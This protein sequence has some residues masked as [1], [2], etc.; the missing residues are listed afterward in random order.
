[1]NFQ[2]TPEEAG[3]RAGVRAWL[4]QHAPGYV[5]PAG[6]KPPHA[7]H[8]RNAKAW[9]ALKA[10][11]GFVGIVWPKA[12]GGQGGTP[13]QQ[14]IFQQEEQR[15][16]LPTGVFSIGLGMCLPTLFTHGAPE[17]AARYV[18]PAMR[19]DEIW[20][21]LFSEPAGGSDVAA[22]RTRAVRVAGKEGGDDEWVINGQ[23]VWTSG[24]KDCDY[25]LLLART[26]PSVPKHAGLTMFFIDM[27]DPAVEVRPI[28]SM[29][30]ESEFNEVFFTDL[31]ISDRQR[32]G[33]PGAGWKVSLTTLMFERLAVGGR[34]ATAPSLDDLM[35]L[36][37]Q[38]GVEPEH[39]AQTLARFYLNDQGIALTRLRLMTALSR[40]QVPGPEAS[41]S[42]LVVAKNLQEMAG[43]AQELAANAA[44]DFDEASP[45]HG[46]TQWQMWSAGLRI[47]GGTDEILRNIIAERVLGLPPEVRLDK[48]TPYNQL[49]A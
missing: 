6:P 38:S 34:P 10:G 11:A 35:G 41:I 21:Q 36:M 32:L 5:V 22:A 8:I 15:Y 48:D 9:Q 47:A 31:R 12:V 45:L 44:M 25:G 24:A 46:F 17:L 27:R 37:R 4:D 40:G 29:P 39:H 1:M 43:F 26:D 18:P 23:K 16:R 42:K 30:G 3:F 28:K 7:K 33:A 49:Q 13:I 19:G 20:C 14:V 2:D